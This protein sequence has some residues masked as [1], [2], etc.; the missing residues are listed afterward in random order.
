MYEKKYYLIIFFIIFDALIIQAIPDK[1]AMTG[2][3][4]FGSSIACTAGIQAWKNNNTKKI[5]SPQ[6]EATISNPTLSN[7]F[8]VSISQTSL[9]GDDQKRALKIKQIKQDFRARQNIK[10]HQQAL[11]PTKLIQSSAHPL[12]LKDRPEFT[13]Y[14]YAKFSNDRLIRTAIIANH[15]G[16]LQPQLKNLPHLKTQ[17][18]QQEKRY[19][20][21]GKILQKIDDLYRA[22]NNDA[23]LKFLEQHVTSLN[24]PQTQSEYSCVDSLSK[25]TEKIDS[26]SKRYTILPKGSTSKKVIFLGSFHGTWGNPSSYGGTGTKALS[27]SFLIYAQR[28]ALEQDAMVYLDIIEWSGK[29]DKNARQKAGQAIAAE[30]A[31][32]IKKTQE[33]NPNTLISVQAIG[34][35]HGCNVINFAAEKLHEANIIIDHATFFGSPVSDIENPKIHH[36]L[37]MFGNLDFTGS[38]GSMI[39]TWGRASSLRKETIDQAKKIQNIVVKSDGE[40][41]NHT[42]IKHIGMSFLPLIQTYVK[43]N[44]NNQRDIILNVYDTS[45]DEESKFEIKNHSEFECIDSIKPFKY[46]IEGMIDTIHAAGSCDFD[47]LEQDAPDTQLSDANTKKYRARYAHKAKSSI[48]FQPNLYERFIGET[49]S[50]HTPAWVLKTLQ[51][52]HAN[53]QSIIGYTESL[54]NYLQNFLVALWNPSLRES[55]ITRDAAPQT[56]SRSLE[57]SYILIPNFDEKIDKAQV[58][59][60]S[61]YSLK[62]KSLMLAQLYAST[63]EYDDP[64]EQMNIIKTLNQKFKTENDAITSWQYNYEWII[65]T[66]RTAENPTWTQ[67]EKEQLQSAK[68]IY[69]RLKENSKKDF[70]GILAGYEDLEPSIQQALLSACQ[71]GLKF[72]NIEDFAKN[73]METQ[74]CSD[75]EIHSPQSLQ[76]SSSQYTTALSSPQGQS[77]S[78]RSPEE[79]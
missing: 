34:H 27:Q 38:I 70:N 47:T 7:K 36:I 40:D 60:A 12:L 74:V 11:I 41:L 66:T 20:K 14:E 56:P 51:Q 48:H 57:S 29:L 1:D 19:Q 9:D 24:S 71:Q 69:M 43:E 54:Q 16:S 21:I 6:S 13:P 73:Y 53:S 49:Q 58:D 61:E 67:P 26:I 39:S 10:L 59:I 64:E 25:I 50:T 63:Q 37:N 76:I 22:H 18:M 46:T 78:L 5:P 52:T 15:V 31:K 68:E 65:G 45:I 79:K 42:S 30:W 75:A 32:E 28:L 72:S 44:F 23:T 33:L 62:N 55:Q 35:S 2:L 4:L 3:V 77:E 8:T 17:Y